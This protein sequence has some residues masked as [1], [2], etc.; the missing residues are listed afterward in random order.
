MLVVRKVNKA[1]YRRFRQKALKKNINVGTAV[2][3]AM[4]TW[5]KEKDEK[6]T[7]NPKALL[8]LKGIIKIGKK[9]RWSEQIDEILYGGMS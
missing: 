1:V 7:I 3:E 2:T 8:K 9:V 6:E 5:L 4:E